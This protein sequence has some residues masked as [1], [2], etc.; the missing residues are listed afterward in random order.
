MKRLYDD[1]KL[2]YKVC[3]L[4]YNENLTQSDIA[5]KL[6]LS[7]P[8]ICRLIQNAKECGIVKIELSDPT[9]HSYSS[10]ERELEDR[11]GMKEVLITES[12]V[13]PDAMMD[14]TGKVAEEYL[15]RIMHNGDLVGVSMGRHISR[16]AK[17][18]TNSKAYPATMFIPLIGG[19][20]VTNANLHSNAIVTELANAFGS[21]YQLLH[22][23]AVVSDPVLVETIKSDKYIS[24]IFELMDRLTIALVGI[25]P[26]SE[27]STL[28]TTG[29][30]T[31]TLIHDMHADGIVGDILL[32]PFDARGVS[33]ENFCRNILAVDI[34]KLK[35]VPYSI[36]IACGA[37]RVPAI[38][39][40]MRA[41]FIN[42]LITD[43][44]TAVQVDKGSQ[45]G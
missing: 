40:S 10:L 19:S 7:R 4:Y 44:D 24:T 35:T 14:M 36:G 33:H 39:A 1:H 9:A 22:V 26:L 25:G 37:D 42:V 8:T 23:P 5:E 38:I 20:G 17:Y 16:I 28:F 13:S 41:K 30:Y 11:F 27:A 43:Y 45:L 29:Y 21:N 6:S 12:S 34:H 15:E 32:Q 18:K 2:M 31:E 3:D